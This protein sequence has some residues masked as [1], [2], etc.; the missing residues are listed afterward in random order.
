MYLLRAPETTLVN[1]PLDLSL[2][3]LQQLYAVD[4]ALPI[5]RANLVTSLDGQISAAQ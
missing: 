2:A 4:E 3:D 1:D 5:V